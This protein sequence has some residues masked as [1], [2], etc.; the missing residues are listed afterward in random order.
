MITNR[1]K[2][3]SV[4]DATDQWRRGVSARVHTEGRHF[5]HHLGL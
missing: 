1:I 5:E 3:E 2:F 4:N